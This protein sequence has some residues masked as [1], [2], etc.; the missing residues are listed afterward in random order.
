MADQQHIIRGINC[1]ITTMVKHTTV[2]LQE[3]TFAGYLMHDTFSDHKVSLYDCQKE[4]NDLVD[5]SGV[6]VYIKC[7]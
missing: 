5:V 1:F 3:R 2:V 6:Y 4:D 7:Y